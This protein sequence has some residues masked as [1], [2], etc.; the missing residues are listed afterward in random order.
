MSEQL[1]M[2]CRWI[3]TVLLVLALGSRADAAA[4]LQFARNGTNLTITAADVD[5]GASYWRMVL[6]ESRGV[7]TGFYDLTDPAGSG[8]NYVSRY[9]WGPGLFA[10]VSID[11]R[12]G[13][14][15]YIAGDAMN[16]QTTYTY[17]LRR[18]HDDGVGYTE[19]TVTVNA[20][21]A[22]GTVMAA[23]TEYS[24][25]VAAGTTKAY[26]AMEL[27]AA[28]EVQM[29]AIYAGS[30]Q[31][32]LDVDGTLW[33]QVEVLGS[34]E[35]AALEL[36]PGRTF[37]VTALNLT[38]GT[39]GYDN[40]T[41]CT[42]H[43][44]FE[45]RSSAGGG[46][47]DNY[48]SK[49]PAGSVFNIYTR[50]EINIVG[51]ALVTNV[52]PVAVAGDDQTIVDME[53][54]GVHDASLD[55][56]ASYDTDG[57]ILGYGWTEAGAPLATGAKPTVSLSVGAHTL[58]LTVTDDQNESGT[59][60]VVVTVVPRTVWTIYVDQSHPN[61]SDANQGTDPD[62]PLATIQAATSQ[63]LN[64]DTII[65][66]AGIYRERVSFGS[67]GTA[68]APIT[69]KAA[70]GERVVVAGSDELAGWTPLPIELARGN[71]HY[72]SIHYVDI[73]WLP[74]RLYEE[75]TRLYPA[76]TP[77][78]GWWV[79]GAGTSGTSLVDPTNLNGPE[80]VD[81][82]GATVFFRDLAPVSN[83][84]RTVVAFDP[85]TGTL[86]LDSPLPDTATPGVDLYY[87]FNRLELLDAPGEWAVED[88]GGGIRRIYIWPGDSGDPADHMYEATRRNNYL[89]NWGDRS[90]IVI[91]GIEVRGGQVVGINDSYGMGSSGTGHNVTVANCTVHDNEFCGVQVRSGSDV[92]I[93]NC[94][95]FANGYGLSTSYS[96]NITFKNN[97]VH[98]NTVDGVLA[99]WN[100]NHVRIEGNYVHDHVLWGHPDNAQ[101]YRDP[102][103]IT[104]LDNVMI[105]A[106]Q[107]VMMEEVVGIDF[108]NNIIVGTHAYM[109]IIG[110]SNC[111]NVTLDGNTLA[112]SGYGLINN[113][114]GTGRDFHNNIFY[115][116][117]GNAMFRLHDDMQ[118]D[119]DYNVFYLGDG[120]DGGRVIAYNDQWMTWDQYYNASGQDQN[121]Q[122]ADPM[123]VNAPKLFDA[124]DAADLPYF[125]ANRVYMRSGTSSH[126]VGD[127]IEIDFDG[128]VRTITAVG[129]DE[130]GGYI[131]YAPPHDRPLEIAGIVCNWR[132]N[133]NFELDFAPAP[134][135]PAIAA[136]VGGRDIGSTLNLADYRAGDF[137]GDGTR[138]VPTWPFGGVVDPPTKPGDANDDGSVDLNDFVILKQNF[139]AQPLTDDR[140][141]F[142]SDGKIDLNDFVILKQNFG[143]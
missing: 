95:I 105:N 12:N 97:E 106:G 11:I 15:S 116:G 14:W 83:S 41:A 103:N 78:H 60:T 110:H 19:S 98:S 93:R 131:E 128:V 2:D 40:A 5:S 139:G 72:A 70:A 94:L 75:D 39:L 76:R 89:V 102:T 129:G 136:G 43:D 73:D 124:M 86:T 111:Y 115:Q 28:D 125:L 51:D 23:R 9:G 8:F 108:V 31:D 74:N 122:Y 36:T 49:P 1:R 55:G 141:D 134:G 24:Y 3:A 107:G 133:D 117:H 77:D 35:A 121:S 140:A 85:A 4:T 27:H 90:Y 109:L 81:W 13:S 71:P 29:N 20:P 21:T 65:V 64:G 67:S 130:H 84:T 91:D 69:L 143:T 33:A 104:F 126:T 7:I 50:L 10:P 120:L 58:T 66:K 48:G 16:G 79:L 42:W 17:T 44:S 142:N 37:R 61:A 138:D 82:V 87:L 127:S 135:S 22:E 45:V 63:A 68:D 46:I 132:D 100:A 30:V 119:S 6:D 54:D 113:T 101:F 38:D 32:T 18:V 57:A 62:A 99:G 123:F 25:A 52:P 88:L 80:A 112:F 34:P 47:Y 114:N 92:T 118:F 26:A 59:D 53:N 56:S 96:S 137:D